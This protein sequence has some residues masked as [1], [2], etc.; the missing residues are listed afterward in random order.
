MKENTKVWLKSLLKILFVTAVLAALCRLPGVRGFLQEDRL[1]AFAETMGWGGVLVLV[2]L[3]ACAPLVL[4]PRLPFALLFGMLYG[5]GKGIALASAAGVGGA[6]LHYLLVARMM[7]DNERAAF[8]SM[9]WYQKL[10][11]V[12]RPFWAITA[13]RLF[14]LSN[15]AVTNIGCALLRIP[16]RAYILSAAV[17]MLPSTVIYVL[18]GHGA[19]A[20]NGKWLLLALAL[21]ASLIP[22]FSWLFRKRLQNQP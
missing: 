1:K 6:V 16:L 20:S 10:R 9:A 17:G 12:P 7:S 15:F 2:A 18:I 21:A 13:I 14:P 11:K 22:V 3:A 8:E 5:V 19:L 4:C